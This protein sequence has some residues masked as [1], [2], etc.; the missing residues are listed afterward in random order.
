MKTFKYK[1]GEIVSWLDTTEEKHKDRIK[2]GYKIVDI[3]DGK[4]NI[5]V[6]YRVEIGVLGVSPYCSAWIKEK[7]ILGVQR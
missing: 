4:A 1:I 5:P 6:D 2:K 7:Q 3:N